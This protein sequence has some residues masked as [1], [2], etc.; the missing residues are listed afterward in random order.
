[1]VEKTPPNRLALDQEKTETVCVMAGKTAHQIDAEAA[2]WAARLDRGPL[3][4][5]DDAALQA[6]LAG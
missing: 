6:W 2:E 4:A 1:M 3:S 5:E